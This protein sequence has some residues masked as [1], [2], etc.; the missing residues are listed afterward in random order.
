MYNMSPLAHVKGSYQKEDYK[1][2]S[3]PMKR[4]VLTMFLV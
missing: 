1:P 4:S 3:E 2:F